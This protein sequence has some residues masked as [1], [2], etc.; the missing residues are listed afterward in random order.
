MQTRAPFSYLRF[1]IIEDEVMQ[2]W[3]VGDLVRDL[4]GVVERVAYGIEQARE[5]LEQASFDCAI[6]DLNLGGIYAYP[7]ADI[8]K[9]RGAAF[10]FCTAYAEGREVF[11]G[12]SE[13]PRVNK[14][15]D[16]TAL[17]DAVLAAINSVR[18][19]LS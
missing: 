10:I 6:V 2:A 13:V 11:H 16:P 14:P 15:V 4:G 9:Q 7:L 12:L 5:A 3:Q 17:C 8:L 19:G 1:L 18:S